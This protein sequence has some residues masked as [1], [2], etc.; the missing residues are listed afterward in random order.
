MICTECTG[1]ID[2]Y[3]DG[4]LDVRGVLDVEA[5]LTTC[6]ACS[7]LV[8]TRRELSRAI[9]TQARRFEPSEELVKRLQASIA[10]PP[11]VARGRSSSR[12]FAVALSCAAA[13]A[14][15]WFAARWHFGGVEAERALAEEVVAAHVRSLQVDHLTDVESSDRHTVNPWFQGKIPFVPGARD[16]ADRGFA[17]A[18]G[19]LDFVDGRAVAAL[20]YRHGPHP[21]NVFTWP[22]DGEKDSA[23]HLL[24]VHGFHVGHI[25]QAGVQRWI[26]SDSDASTVAKLAELLSAPE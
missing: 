9:R 16:F 1:L 11:V 13:L 20:V 2:A 17:L 23:L 8:Q 4:E 7:K 18:G 12:A 10:P 24:D 6:R 3:I 25:S 15:V 22:N 19:R 21:L 5:H 14:F 26:V